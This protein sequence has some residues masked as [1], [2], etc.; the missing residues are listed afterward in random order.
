MSR[1][2]KRLRRSWRWGA[3]GCALLALCGSIPVAWAR[4]DPA[5]TSLYGYCWT[6][7]N[8]AFQQERHI[9][10]DITATLGNNWQRAHISWFVHSQMFTSAVDHANAVLALCMRSRGFAGTD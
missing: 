9:D 5:P 1:R 3:L 7:A 8:A 10:Q 4:P 6:R 2:E